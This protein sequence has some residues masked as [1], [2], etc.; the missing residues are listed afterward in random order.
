MTVQRSFRKWENWYYF[1]TLTLP[2]KGRI[3]VENRE[4]SAFCA[5]QNE[6]VVILPYLHIKNGSERVFRSVGTTKKD[7]E[8]KLCVFVISIVL[9]DFYAYDIALGYLSPLAVNVSLY[10]VLVSLAF[11]NVLKANCVSCRISYLYKQLPEPCSISTLLRRSWKLPSQRAC[12][13][14]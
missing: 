2:G 8:P 1:S 13:K 11:G 4:F 7:A 3:R 10:S 14:P 12:S 5:V 6:W 9:L